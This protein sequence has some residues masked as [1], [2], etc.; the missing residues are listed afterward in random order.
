MYVCLWGFDASIM[1]EYECLVKQML[2]IGKASK[3]KKQVKKSKK[4]ELFIGSIPF[5]TI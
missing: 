5:Q 4:Q 2:V 1:G 3:D